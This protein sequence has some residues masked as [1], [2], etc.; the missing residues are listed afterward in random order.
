M[1]RR[2]L[3]PATD[4]SQVQTH[5]YY[6]RARGQYLNDQATLT[7]GEKS[8]FLR[9]HP[10]PQVITKT[11]L[12]KVETC[13]A[14]EPDTACR[15]AEKAFML[16]AKTVTDDWKVERKRAEYTDDWFRGAVARTI[17]FRATEKAV[18]AAA[19]YEGG[20]RAQVVAYICARLVRLASDRTGGGRLDYRRIWGVQGL[21]DVFRRQLDAVGEAMMT[22][23]RSPPREGQNITEWAKQQA[24]REVAMKTDVQVSEGIDAWLI[25]VDA[26]R[27]ERKERRVAGEVDDDL[28]AIQ[29]VMSIPNREWVRLREGLRRERLIHGTDEPALRAAC[30]ETGRPPNEIQTKRLLVLLQRAEEV[31]LKPSLAGAQVSS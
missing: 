8:R 1:S 15:G 21:D 2:I 12:A 9:I 23:L 18:S 16:F 14:G 3:A 11:D 20:Y 26:D 7:P 10:K 27:S 24:C 4:G 31:G 6:E 22:V 29:T 19:W 13:F 25:G 28:R 17:I 5:W 30:G